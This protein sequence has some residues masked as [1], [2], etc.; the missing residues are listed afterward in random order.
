MYW[1]RLFIVVGN[2]TTPAIATNFYL[3]SRLYTSPST[4]LDNTFL[5]VTHVLRPTKKTTID[6]ANGTR[7]NFSCGDGAIPDSARRCEMLFMQHKTC[8]PTTLSRVVAN[9]YRKRSDNYVIT[10]FLL[11]ITRICNCCASFW[12]P[13]T[14]FCDTMSATTSKWLISASNTR[15]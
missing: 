13:Y 14:Y 15:R 9:C 12:P 4:N 2:G 11:K 3:Q 8:V 7:A 5:C 10:L 6:V 1:A